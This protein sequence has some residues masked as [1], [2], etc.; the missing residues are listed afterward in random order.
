VVVGQIGDPV[1]VRD[2]LGDP[3][4]PLIGM[5]EEAF[6]VASTLVSA[7]IVAV[8]SSSLVRADR[9]SFLAGARHGWP[10]AGEFAPR[11]ERVPVDPLEG[12]LAEVVEARLA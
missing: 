4:V 8:I 12:E 6:G 11:Q 3:L 5:C 1:L 7:I 9:Y 10:D 2:L